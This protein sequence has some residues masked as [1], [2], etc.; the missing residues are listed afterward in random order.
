M[1]QETYTGQALAFTLDVN[2]KATLAASVNSGGQ[3]PAFVTPINN[4]TELFMPNYNSGQIES[5]AITNGGKGF[6]TPSSVLQLVGSG[7]N[8]NRQASPHPH[9][10]GI[11]VH[12]S[13]A[14]CLFP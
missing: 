9:E 6:G 13:C 8:Y 11:L 14:F 7:P 4:G 2:G 3:N 1:N 10:V 12:M 5:V